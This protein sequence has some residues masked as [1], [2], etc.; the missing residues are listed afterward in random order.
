MS[1]VDFITTARVHQ[2]Y[3]AATGR[4]EEGVRAGCVEGAIDNA[5][6]AASYAQE[7]DAPDPLRIAAYLLRSLARNHCYVDGNKRIAWVTCLEVL[8]V[9][10]EVTVEEDEEAAALFVESVATGALDVEGIVHWLA[11]RLVDLTTY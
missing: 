1:E 11:V 6:L 3:R 9:G 2:L 5:V 8:A 10:A 4:S 7:S